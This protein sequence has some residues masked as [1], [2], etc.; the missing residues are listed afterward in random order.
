M[1]LPNILTVLRVLS[2]PFFVY[3][4]LQ[5][6]LN[7]RI[8]AFVLFA[9]ASVTDLIDG[10]LARRWNQET[11]LG[12]FLDPLADKFLV[13]GAF[14]TFLFLTEQT[15]L[16]MVLC[17]I[18]RDMLITIM[19]W[20]AIQLGKSLRTS[21]FGKI[22]TG[23]QMFAIVVIVFSFLVVTYKERT[24]IN[25]FYLN[26]ALQGQD[27][28]SVAFENL[29]KTIRGEYTS[30]FYAL[31]SFVPYFLMLLTTVITIISGLRYLFTNYALFGSFLQLCWQRF[32]G[33][34]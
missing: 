3:L 14:I 1:N 16:W 22:K 34:K 26:A 19:R 9:L 6:D 11:E 12:K 5:P 17:I 20:M 21:V 7:S 23:F 32:P 33:R 13:L 31:S 10:Y 27:T 28:F 2:A 4:L 24:S 25:E 18:G 29:N 30:L 15:E 8:I